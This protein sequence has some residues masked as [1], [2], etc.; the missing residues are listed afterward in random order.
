MGRRVIHLRWPATC[1]DCGASLPKGAE[2]RYYGSKQVY[3]LHCHR[4]EAVAR[5]LRREAEGA[6]VGE[7][8]SIL[9]PHGAFT[10]DGEQIGSSCGCEDY[11]CCGH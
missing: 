4:G 10:P 8:A 11:P 3:G 7:V 9:N 1:A 5:A 2:V 6:D